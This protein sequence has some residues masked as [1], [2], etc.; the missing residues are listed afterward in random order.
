M[1]RGQEPLGIKLQE[2]V[3]VGLHRLLEVAI[4]QAD[5]RQVKKLDR[6]GDGILDFQR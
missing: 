5:I 6:I 3:Q 1:L 2:I 4:Q